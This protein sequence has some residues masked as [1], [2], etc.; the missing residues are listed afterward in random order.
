MKRI[1]VDTATMQGSINGIVTDINNVRTETD[2]AYEGIRVLDTM[3]EGSANEAFN[4][5]FVRDY[6]R[7]T[8]ICDVLYEFADKLSQ[9]K[10]G[11]EN[12]ERSVASIVAA[13]RI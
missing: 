3:W 1:E 12:G 8:E 4:L 10:N 6:E 9:A 2:T 5:Q 13:I 11:Y 7:M